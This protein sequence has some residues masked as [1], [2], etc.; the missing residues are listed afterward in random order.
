MV[1]VHIQASTTAL[2]QRPPPRIRLTIFTHREQWGADIAH[3]ILR[4]PVRPVRRTLIPILIIRVAIWR[5]SG[6][7]HMLDQLRARVPGHSRRILQ[8]RRLRE[9]HNHSRFGGQRKDPSPIRLPLAPSDRRWMP[10]ECQMRERRM[11]RFYR[12]LTIR[13]GRANSTVIPG[14]AAHFIVIQIFRT[15][16]HWWLHIV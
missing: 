13:P 6:S 15:L 10:V 4:S 16:Q 7:R 8:H 5:I 11:R 9:D 14:Q 1:V 3:N 2:P 12:R